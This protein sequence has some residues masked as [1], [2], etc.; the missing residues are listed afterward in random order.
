MRV[1]D[2][3]TKDTI[4]AATATLAGAA[5]EI[6]GLARRSPAAYI[7]ATLSADGRLLGLR[8]ADACGADASAPLRVLFDC[9]AARSRKGALTRIDEWAGKQYR[10]VGRAPACE[11]SVGGHGRECSPRA[12]GLAPD[13][14]TS[15]ISH[16]R[17]RHRGRRSGAGRRAGFGPTAGGETRVGRADAAAAPLAGDELARRLA[18][19]A[20]AMGLVGDPHGGYR[21]AHRRCV[22]TVAAGPR[23]DDGGAR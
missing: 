6:A 9:R 4:K 3:Y 5:D 12:S 15:P 2:T 8:G 10:R 17:K 18:H 13:A 16:G 19:V 22:A 23:G 7:E 1:P 21:A 14:P 20:A 11:G